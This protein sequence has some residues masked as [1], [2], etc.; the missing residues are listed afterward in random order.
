MKNYGVRDISVRGPFK[1]S[2]E[3][4][5]TLNATIRTERT[6]PPPPAIEKFDK[7]RRVH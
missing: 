5:T 7:A 1:R 2:S 6:L 3:L 4:E